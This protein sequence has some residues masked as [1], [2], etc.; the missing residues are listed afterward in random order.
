M[1]GEFEGPSGGVKD[2]PKDLLLLGPSAVPLLE[3]L[4]GD[5]FLPVQG[6]EVPLGKNPVHG[7]HDAATHVGASTPGALSN[8][9]EIINKYVNMSNGSSV[10]CERGPIFGLRERPHELYELWSSVLTCRGAIARLWRGWCR[11]GGDVDS[12]RT[13]G[14]RPSVWISGRSP[15]V[16]SGGGALK[17]VRRHSAAK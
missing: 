1:V 11:Y 9:D 16:M 6:V 2:P 12:R 14:L 15:T 13:E 4:L 5:G 7:M 8:P 3:L 17:A 10:P